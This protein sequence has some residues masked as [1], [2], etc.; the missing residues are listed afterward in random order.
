MDLVFLGGGDTKY[1]TDELNNLGFLSD[2]IEYNLQNPQIVSKLLKILS[3]G[4]V[5]L[6]KG[7][8]AVRLDEVV[9]RITKNKK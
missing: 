5:V 6:V 1:I 4:D 7:S 3:K 2:R 8:R 9:Q